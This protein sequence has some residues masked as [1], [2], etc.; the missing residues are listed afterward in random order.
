MEQAK[1]KR[2]VLVMGSESFAG[3]QDD[4]A[5][6]LDLGKRVEISKRGR[7]YL[8]SK[9]PAIQISNSLRLTR[10]VIFTL[11]GSLSESVFE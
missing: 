7:I 10:R 11:S 8:I 5:T 4:L 6:L 3:N 2:P 9:H 1:A